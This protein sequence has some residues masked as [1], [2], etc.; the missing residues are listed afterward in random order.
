MYSIERAEHV[1]NHVLTSDL[2]HE[3]CVENWMW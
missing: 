2:F 1:D 3:P